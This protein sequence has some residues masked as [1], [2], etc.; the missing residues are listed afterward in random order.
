MPTTQ[1]IEAGLA[2]SG[3]GPVQLTP[4]KPVELPP[5]YVAAPDQPSLPPPPPVQPQ[6]VDRQAYWMKVQQE[7]QLAEQYAAM[8]QKYVSIG[9]QAQAESDQAQMNAQYQNPATADLARTQERFQRS[10]PYTGFDVLNPHAYFEADI[11][12]AK[13]I[14]DA[15]GE[16]VGNALQYAPGNLIAQKLGAGDVFGKDFTPANVGSTL[17]E[18][19]IPTTLGAAAPEAIPGIGLGPDALGVLSRIARNAGTS[20]EEFV[21]TDAGRAAIKALQEG[22]A[23]QFKLPFRKAPLDLPAG[24]TALESHVGAQFDE[25]GN[26]VPPTN[27]A[28]RLNAEPSPLDSA[29]LQV[30]EWLRKGEKARPEQEVLFQQ[31]RAARAQAMEAKFR[32][33]GPN[34]AQEAK[35]AGAGEF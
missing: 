2:P 35:A 21:A 4:P 3:I 9:H 20:V 23:G 7:R 17:A 16:G 11:P 18:G 14:R 33:N 28:A 29:A 30:S 6:I 31:E 24:Q 10:E 15:V 8:V 5:Y 22:E 27:L 32:A 19:L 12:G 1:D 26:P 34:A 25:L 13:A